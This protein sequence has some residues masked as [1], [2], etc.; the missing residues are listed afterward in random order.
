M[1]KSS[2]C[3]DISN[4]LTI[5][6]YGNGVKLIRPDD[7][8]I[9]NALRNE[10]HT[11]AHAS[12]LAFS[13]CLLNTE[14]EILRMN[15]AGAELNGFASENDIVG[16]SLFDLY[17]R[18]NAQI[19][20]NDDI[21]ILKSKNICIDENK[22]ARKDGV[23]F[24]NLTIDAPWYDHDDK[25]IGLLGFSVVLGG[26]PATPVEPALNYLRDLGLLAPLTT[27]I[28]NDISLTKREKSCLDQ[29]MIG[30]SYKQIGE[31]LHISARTVEHC[32]ER[33]KL[34][35]GVKTKFQLIE[36]MQSYY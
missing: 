22:P 24:H 19:L 36:A 32:I 14:S 5:Q 4:E 28:V 1:Y 15:E 26:L 30:K 31:A 9:S 21:N 10:S 12:R 13:F 6:R 25:L 8:T 17:E 29:L 2:N 16:K 11:L 7:M 20:R 35:F 23:T 18:D 34:K 27:T 33:I 3:P